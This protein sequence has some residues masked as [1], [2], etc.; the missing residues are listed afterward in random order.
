M[1]LYPKG[2]TQAPPDKRPG[3]PDQST[4]P[5]RK[6]VILAAGIGDR[7]RPFTHTHPKC[8]VTVAGVPIL[9]NAL[10]RLSEV[11]TKDVVIVVGHFGDMI[12][13]RF[14]HH[15]AGMALTY[16]VS[17]D[18]RTTN[19]IYSLWLVRS[20]L[21]ED[22]LLLE[23]DV[24]FERAVLDRLLSSG[25]GN[26]AAVSQHQSWMSGTVVSLDADSRSRLFACDALSR[27]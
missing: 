2:Q 9:E 22:V 10:L 19:N 1:Q 15:F 26:L 27:C 18:F 5:V 8:L 21:T 7:L 24:F 12:K 17:E 20:H 11:G 16:V 13:D 6:A 14:G 23:A 25:P 4:S 3:L